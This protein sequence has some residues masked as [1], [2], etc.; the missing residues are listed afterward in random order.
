MRIY[1]SNDRNAECIT[2]TEITDTI[3]LIE[4]TLA[5]ATY[6]QEYHE[7]IRYIK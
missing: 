4:V 6:K 3:R 2:R 5:I 7:P 1:A